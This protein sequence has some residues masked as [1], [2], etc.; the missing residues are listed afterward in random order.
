MSNN[1]KVVLDKSTIKQ[2]TEK[3]GKAIGMTAKVLQDEI[4][5]EQVIPRDIGTLQGDAFEIGEVM[6]HP[7][8]Y[9]VR[10]SFNTPYARR[11]YYHPEYHFSKE[12]NANAQGLWMTAW[13]KGGK[14]EKRPKEIFEAIYHKML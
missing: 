9:S 1:C 5:E 7:E 4:R 3:T 8:G 13:F 14:Y 10:M 12:I 2:I 6:K 11:L